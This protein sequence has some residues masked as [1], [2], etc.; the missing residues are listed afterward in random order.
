M[1]EYYIITIFAITTQINNEQNTKLQNTYL[2]ISNNKYLMDIFNL[3]IQL[4]G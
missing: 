4:N 3:I 2:P 1:L